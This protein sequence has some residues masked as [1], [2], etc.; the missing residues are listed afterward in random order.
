MTITDSV[1]PEAETRTPVLQARRL[2]K[3]FGRVVGLDGGDP[4]GYARAWGA[5]LVLIAIVM[6]LNLL[7][8][9]IG[10]YFAPKTE[11]RR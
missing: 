3:T 10:A 8:R 1:V 11:R 2:V 7:A 9:I 5:A 4:P 6:V